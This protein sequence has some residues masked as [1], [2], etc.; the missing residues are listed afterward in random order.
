MSLC[1]KAEMLMPITI[2]NKCE[3]VFK[4]MKDELAYEV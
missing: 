4:N 3:Q 1:V 2:A